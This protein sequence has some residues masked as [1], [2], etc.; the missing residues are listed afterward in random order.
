ASIAGA[1][2]LLSGNGTS[3][4]G[5]GPDGKYI[6]M[7]SEAAESKGTATDFPSLASLGGGV[8]G[9]LGG[10]GSPISFAMGASGLKRLLDVE[11]PDQQLGA[12]DQV[13]AWDATNGSYDLGFPAQMNDLQFFNTPAIADVN[14]DGKPDVIEGSAV[15]DLRAY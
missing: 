1:P 2:Y 11:L 6:T 14:G 3:F 4:Y 13:S 8:F 10:P 12:E 9:R 5:K 15:Y 7:A